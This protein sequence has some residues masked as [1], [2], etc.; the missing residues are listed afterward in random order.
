MLIPRTKLITPTLLLL[1]ALLATAVTPLNPTGSLPDISL[2]ET[3][4]FSADLSQAFNL[5]VDPNVITTFKSNGAGQTFGLFEPYNVQ[6]Y[7]FVVGKTY[8]NFVDYV[9]FNW[10][11]MV[12]GD[13]R[14]TYQKLTGD[15]QNFAEYITHDFYVEGVQMVCTG[16]AFNPK[17][18][19]AYIGCFDTN[20]TPG[21]PGSLR[22]FT[23]DL[24]KNEVVAELQEFQDGSN[25][26]KN[27]LRMFIHNFTHDGQDTEYL[28]AYDEGH[29]YDAKNDDQHLELRVFFNVEKGKLEQ[30][31]I[32][33]IKNDTNLAIFYD[34][35]PYPR[36]GAANPG[37]LLLTGRN[38]PI[39]TESNIT[40][41]RC[42][43]N[44][45]DQTLECGDDF[46]QLDT[47]TGKA[48]VLGP[49][50]ATVNTADQSVNFRG[51]GKDF[52]KDFLGPIF[53]QAT[54][55][56]FPKVDAFGKKLWIR[57]AG[58]NSYGASISYGTPE[59]IDQG[60][61]FINWRAGRS[62]YMQ[63][64]IGCVQE[65]NYVAAQEFGKFHLL[66]LYRDRPFFRITPDTLKYSDNYYRLTAKDNSSFAD[67]NNNAVL[68]S[69]VY[70]RI[71]V[72]NRFGVIN[73]TE[74]IP[75]E[76]FIRPEDVFWGNA[77]D[78]KVTVDD[79]RLL[80][81]DTRT[82]ESVQLKL[83]GANNTQGGELLFSRNTLV[84]LNRDNTIVWSHCAEYVNVS[85]ISLT[86]VECNQTGAFQFRAKDELGKTIKT[87]NNIS[88]IYSANATGSTA[89]I[90][91]NNNGKHTE[92]NEA[93]PRIVDVGISFSK[94][95][96]YAIVV[97]DHK[98][99]VYSFTP[100]NLTDI[101]LVFKISEVELG[102]PFCPLGYNNP[103]GDG[104][105]V[106][107]LS[108]CL[109][110]FG[111]KYVVRLGVDKPEFDFV[112]FDQVVEI[113]R[114][115][116]GE[117]EILLR[118]YFD[119]YGLSISDDFNRWYVPTK[120]L[121]MKEGYRMWCV[122]NVNKAAFVSLNQNAENTLHSVTILN[123]DTGYNQ[124]R[125]YPF[126]LEGIEADYIRVFDLLGYPIIVIHDLGR[127]ELIRPYDA[128]VIRM[129]PGEVNTVTRVT[130]NTTFFNKESQH[131][132]LNY[133]YIHPKAPEY[134]V[135]AVETEVFD[136]FEN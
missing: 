110:P 2:L 57:T 33:Q 53:F 12:S 59:H 5:S 26:I 135:D 42:K 56:T 125:R 106:D 19:Y 36:E 60:T 94:N 35:Y 40:I 47:L 112:E 25:R 117:N 9:G 13:T 131:V 81:A 90:L 92:L 120:D 88:I 103:K 66:G 68:L 64:Y 134:E 136:G 84:N 73:L 52:D 15:G 34:I 105:T 108:S 61:T 100:A 41:H 93:D 132:Q 104:K 38:K 129:S 65:R 97:L 74:G 11:I 111:T 98:V 31:F 71:A 72:N 54:N 7:N 115:C 130:V 63:Y 109:G 29:P 27:R 16:H 86:H 77:L 62:E 122:E 21:N 99:K 133:A 101:K 8:F 95:I 55:L 70:E 113:R 127:S 96:Y 45:N 89:Y 82:F 48:I 18:V 30:D 126:Q 118:G 20:T 119:T 3:D 14:V 83:N 80:L 91:N 114:F 51:L 76:Y 128:P 10:V 4:V 58:F 37:D 50:L 22:I 24:V 85:Q 32:A 67:Y 49:I 123:L 43:L 87:F 121:G 69:S 6:P 17:R 75:V 78:V 44:W 107:I 79:E 46:K 1:A 39:N 28:I 124:A 23:W 102:R 116:S